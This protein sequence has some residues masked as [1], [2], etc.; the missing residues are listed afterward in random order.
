[1]I[2]AER[3]GDCSTAGSAETSRDDWVRPR[4]A[5]LRHNTSD[6]DSL[7]EQHRRRPQRLLVSARKRRP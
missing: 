5:R 4:R 7:R 2:S 3:C 1:V 6:S